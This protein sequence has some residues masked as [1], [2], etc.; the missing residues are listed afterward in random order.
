MRGWL[1]TFSTLRSRDKMKQRFK[2]RK[3]KGVLIFFERNER[4]I[5]PG[6]YKTFQ[7]K[8]KKN[9]TLAKCIFKSVPFSTL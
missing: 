5:K 1:L 7:Q 8:E 4:N 2:E 3:F 9:A 6:N